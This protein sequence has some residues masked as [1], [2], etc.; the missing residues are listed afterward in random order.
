MKGSF[1]VLRRLRKLAVILGIVV[2]AVVATVFVVRALDSLR[3]PDLAL[4]HTFVPE[5]MTVA[6]MDAADWSGYLAAEDRVFQ[7]V[8]DNVTLK[9][10]PRD[11][12]VHDR[13]FADA[14]VYPGNFTQDFNRSYLLEPE[15]A[16]KGAAVFLHG[17]TDAPYSL[18]HLAEL[19]RDRGYVAVLV[20]MPGHGTVPAGLTEATWEEWMAATRLAVRAAVARAGA[21]VPLHVVGYSNGGALAV[22]YALD[23]LAD[24]ALH[25]PDQLVLLSPMIGVT[26]FARFAGLAGWPAIFPPFVKAAWLSILPEYNPFKYNSFPVNAGRESWRLVAALQG[27]ID[28]AVRDG[29]MAEM[30]P[31]L[32]FQSAIDFTVSTSAV[33]TALY[34]HLPDNGSDLVLFDVNRAAKLGVLLRQRAKRAVETLLPPAPRSYATSIVGNAA[35]GEAAVVE[36]RVAADGTGETVT[37]LGVDYPRDVFS[38]SH[39]AMPFPPWDSLYGAAPQPPDA[40]G[41]S[42]GDI[43]A[44][45]ETGAL[46]V[47]LDS[48]LRNT[49]N[50]FYAYLA[51]R[52]GETIDA[53]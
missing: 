29:R 36:R 34:A 11:R 40:F 41:V 6:E 48:L 17:L 42:L 25:R 10:P 2:L 5:E 38:L 14:P 12:V 44:R 32:T 21:D 49:S 30:P 39:I 19:Y 50:P 13:Y 53:P 18:R 28:A 1:S 46:I 16:P 23:A 8:H 20:R 4:W 37:P 22:K 9:L 43:A 3:G 7:S 33:V 26:R 45:G 52:I 31:V 35:P 24:P 51:R 47:G 27:E 15:G